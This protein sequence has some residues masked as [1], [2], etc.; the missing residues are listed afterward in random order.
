MAHSAG[1]L[2]CLGADEIVM[3][4]MADL[5][6]VDPSVANQFN[7]I[8]ETQ[9]IAQGKLPA[10]RPRIPISVEDLAA[11]LTLAR[12]RAGLEG[13]PSMVDAFRALTDKIHPLALGN[14]HRQHMLIRRLVRRLLGMHMSPSVEKERISQITENLTEKLYAHEYVMSREE[15]KNE[16]GLKV[17]YPSASLEAYMWSLYRLFEDYLCVDR[18]VDVLGLLGSE[19]RKYAII[20]SAAIESTNYLHVFAYRGWFTR[21]GQEMGYDGESAAWEQVI[22]R[23][24]GNNEEN[25]A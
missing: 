12:E 8:V 2:I 20:E 11:Y 24:V 25:S 18:E 16:M 7:P 21:K 3:G 1:T 23:G 14:I 19:S 6:P 13:G 5:G 22:P 9:D 15:A 10:P 4:R 17:T